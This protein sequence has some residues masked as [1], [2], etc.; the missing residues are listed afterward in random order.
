[1]PEVEVNRNSHLIDPQLHIWGWE[2]P[3][4]LFL[5]GLAAGIMVFSALLVLRRNQDQRSKWSRWMA[6]VAPALLS[7]GMFALLLD[8]EYKLHVWRFYAAFQVAS[9][10]SWG[11]WILL[12]IY[13]ATLALGLATL[14][15]DERESLAGWKLTRASRLA[16]ALRATDAWASANVRSIAWTNLLL[17]IAL[18]IYTGIL[19]GSLGARPAWNSAVLGPLFLVSGIS[20][21]AAL[22]MLFPL[23]HEEHTFLQ[24]WDVAAI[25]L[26][27]LLLFLFLMTLLTGGGQPGR[28]A[29]GLFLGGRYTALFWSLV[30]IVGLAI[31]LTLEVIEIVK[32]RRPT[33][34]TPVLLLI[35]GL[36][37]R[38]ILVAAGQ[39]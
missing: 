9:P 31:P 28:D 30:V 26:E 11:S 36:A 38:W 32:R 7:I 18:G 22:M 13:P 12:L 10:M 27:A 39:A 4:Y 6:F 19:L 2:V 17:G 20:T 3:L 5:G 29:A 35:G 33:V 24:R 8:L 15:G 25:L 21:G 23:Q 16:D 37:L 14:T 34:V 1:M